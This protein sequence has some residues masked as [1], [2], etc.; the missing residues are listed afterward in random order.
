VKRREVLVTLLGGAAAWPLAARAQQPVRMRRTGMLMAYAE[1]DW[2]GQHFAATFVEELAKLGWVEGRTVQI[3]VRWAPASADADARLRVARELIAFRPDLIVSHGTPNTSTLHQLTRTVP[4]VFVNASDPIGSGFVASF[5]RPGGNITGFIT[6]EP[7]MAGKWLELLKEIAPAITNCA[8]LFNPE[9]APYA[10]YF[11]KPFNAAAAS[12]AVKGTIAR[13]LDVGQLDT[14]IA[15][16]TREPNGSLVVM[17]DTFMTLHRAKIT[18]L[19][20]K[21][22]LP[23]AY[24]FRF[25]SASGG[26]LSYGNDTNDSFRRAAAYADRIIRGEKPNELPVQAPTKF[27]LVINL[28]T[29]KALGLNVPPTLLARA[30][31]VIE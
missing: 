9:T 13:V 15:E 21:H 11:V 12:L 14:A 31:E 26:L 4:I 17:P 2:E 1:S 19:A 29:A 27:E 5:P 30:E 28:K 3:D 23:A 25:Y 8:L 22:A 10:D 6:M 18:A 20:H 16:L 7:T 24:P